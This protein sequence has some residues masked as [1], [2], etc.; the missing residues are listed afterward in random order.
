MCFRI[1]FLIWIWIF[2]VRN[3]IRFLIF[4]VLIFLIS[5][6]VLL[7]LLKTSDVGVADLNLWFFELLEQDNPF[8]KLRL[9]F[10]ETGCLSCCPTSGSKVGQ[11]DQN[12][13]KR[14]TLKKE[15]KQLE[16]SKLQFQRKRNKKSNNPNK[17]FSKNKLNFE[18]YCSTH[19][20]SKKQNSNNSNW[21]RPLFHNQN[22]NKFEFANSTSKNKIKNQIIKNIKMDV[23][24]L[25]LRKILKSFSIVKHQT[26]MFIILTWF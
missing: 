26:A 2:A 19:Q 3:R 8:S 10:F 15:L 17:Q 21:E 23:S 5:R 7:L 16:Q 22:I 18:I 6:I 14:K 13:F 24:I 25:R 4:D 20:F 9:F 1:L 11:K 12:K